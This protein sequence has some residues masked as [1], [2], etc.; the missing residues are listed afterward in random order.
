M[1][2]FCPYSRPQAMLAL[3]LCLIASVAQATDW[4]TAAHDAARSGRTT[5][6]APGPYRVRWAKA[7]QYKNIATVNQLIV[8]QGRGYIGTLGSEGSFAG[9]IHC[10]DLQTGKDLWTYR[11]LVGGVAHSLSWSPQAGGTVCAATTC[12][13]VVAL[14]SATGKLRW[15]FVMPLGGFVVNPCVSEGAVLLGSRQGIFYALN[16]TDGSIRRERDV[17]IP[18]CNTAAAADGIVYFLDEGLHTHALTIA[19]GQP[20]ARWNYLVRWDPPVQEGEVAAPWYSTTI[21]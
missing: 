13:E 12:G 2:R 5:D 11:D 4:P 18:I 1:W 6:T 17:D 19:T 15:K 14:E 7:W 3:G 10:V 21:N 16:E 8:A 20:A 9:R